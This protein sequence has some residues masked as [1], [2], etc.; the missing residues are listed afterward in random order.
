MTDIKHFIAEQFE[1]SI[2]E[3]LQALEIKVNDRIVP[4]DYFEGNGLAFNDAGQIIRQYR[5]VPAVLVGI[6]DVDAIKSTDVTKTVYFNKFRLHILIQCQ[7]NNRK[8]GEFSDI[9]N[10]R[11]TIRREIIGNNP[12]NANMDKVILDFISDN[13]LIIIDNVAIYEQ[14]YEGQFIERGIQSGAST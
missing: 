3:S 4:I 1:D 12:Y 11:R 6:G 9:K 14:I 7:E 8:K 2:I 10:L 13:A 5:A